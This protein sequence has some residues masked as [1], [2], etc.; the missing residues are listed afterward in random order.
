MQAIPLLR[1][2]VHL[3]VVFRGA[4]ELRRP[5]H[6]GDGS[7]WPRHRDPEG[8]PPSM[9]RTD[10]LLCSAADASVTPE[11]VCQDCIALHQGVLHGCQLFQP[12]DCMKSPRHSRVCA[13]ESCGAWPQ[14]SCNR[15]ARQHS[16]RDFPIHVNQQCCRAHRF[17]PW[18]ARRRASQSP[19]TMTTAARRRRR[20]RIT[21]THR[22]QHRPA[23]SQPQIEHLHSREDQM[24]HHLMRVLRPTVTR[25]AS[26][27]R[28]ARGS[29]L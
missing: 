15:A 25:A 11:S 27:C 26:P 20:H 17:F 14:P 16:T 18:S 3:A 9:T 4:A 24:V 13:C 12:Q 21:T 22:G 5:A 7:S 28:R 19:I 23:L 2:A 8:A 6:P 1:L 10:G 29:I